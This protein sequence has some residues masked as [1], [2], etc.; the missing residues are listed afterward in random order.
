MDAKLA[1]FTQQ[2]IIDSMITETEV[3]RNQW[4]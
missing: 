2:T 3:D 1:D 4:T